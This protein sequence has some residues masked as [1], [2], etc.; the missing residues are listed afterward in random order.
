[1]KLDQYNIYF[2]KY[3]YD[4]QDNSI[5]K[6]KKTNIIQDYDKLFF[7]LL[8][9]AKYPELDMFYNRHKEQ[10]IKLNICN[11]LDDYKIKQKTRICERLS[12]E[13]NIDLPVFD[14]LVMYFNLNIC[15]VCEN[16][17][18]KMF[19]NESSDNY[20]ITNKDFTIKAVKYEKI[21]EVIDNHYEIE[22]IFK[23]LNAPS[24]YK[25]DQL[26]KIALKLKISLKE[27]IKKSELHEIIIKHLYNMYPLF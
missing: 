23:P 25:L 20:Y 24:Y 1:M 3:K 17:Y 6:N 9:I 16:I 11:N 10:H 26:K 15:Y 18:I 14:A 2:L 7:N 21:Q 12:Y 13:K 19:Y 8:N 4:I 27:K 22:N 5:L